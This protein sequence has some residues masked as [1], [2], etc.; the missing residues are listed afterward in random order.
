MT[1]IRLSRSRSLDEAA[2]SVG[3]DAPLLSVIVPARDEEENIE[4]CLR[5]ILATSYPRL[6]LVLVDDHSRDPTR[7]IAERIAREDARLRVVS[8]PDLPAGWFGKPWACATGAR[9]ARGAILCFMDADTTQSPDLLPRMVDTMRARDAGMLTVAGAQEMHTFWETLLQPQVFGMLLMRYGGTESVN[10]SRHAWDKIANGQCI[11]IRRA[12]YESIG[13][14]GAVRDK[15]AEDLMLAQRLFRAGVH[16]VLV[17]GVGQLS[18]RMY[19]S[20]GALV[21]GWRKNVFAG[22]IDALPAMAIAR[23]LFPVALT[24]FPLA[25]LV[26]VATLAAHAAGAAWP[27]PTAL[28]WAWIATTAMLVAWSVVYLRARRSPLWAALFPL[29]ALVLLWIILGAIARWRR[30]S[31]KGRTYRAA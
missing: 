29:G 26:P 13:G 30:V 3:E 9:E 12:A 15:V 19:S 4:R 20:L 23:A 21:R 18:T 2:P 10:E 27:G 16:T 7:R 25:E 6:E 24:L 5:S 17:L 14:H 8:A 31:W 1:A 11:A 22:G 28:T